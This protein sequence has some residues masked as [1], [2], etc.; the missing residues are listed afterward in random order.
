MKNRLIRTIAAA[1][2]ICACA[3]PALAGGFGI[4]ISLPDR[5]NPATKDA[6]LIVQPIGC[7]GPGSSVSARAEGLVNG[8]RKTI[9]VTLTKVPKASEKEFYDTYTVKQQW[10]KEGAWILIAT[11]E[12]PFTANGKT[13]TMSTSAMVSFDAS[14]QPE[15]VTSGDHK[16]QV[17][18]GTYLWKPTPENIDKALRAV[19]ERQGEK[20]P[21]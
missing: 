14:G 19:A 11:A 3:C 15:K 16:G 7:H 6:F 2:A 17:K 13:T 20:R 1:A 18:M 4:T 5:N 12:Q 10:P 21:G 9:T 8:V